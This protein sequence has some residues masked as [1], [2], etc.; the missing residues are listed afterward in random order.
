M[1]NK[2]KSPK[3]TDKNWSVSKRLGAS[4]QDQGTH[5]RSGPT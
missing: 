3:M 5:I 1:K 2:K 4:C